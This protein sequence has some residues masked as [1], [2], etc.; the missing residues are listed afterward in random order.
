[1]SEYT[2][3]NSAAVID[4]AISSVAGADATPTDGSQNMVTSGGVKT[5]VDG[6]VGDFAGK[7]VTESTDTFTDSDSS[8]P[9]NAAVVDYVSAQTIVAVCKAADGSLNL[10]ANTP[11]N[12]SI[13]YQ[14]NNSVSISGS[15][16][17]LAEGSYLVQLSGNF[18]E[19]DNDV[20]D[21]AGVVFL[22]NNSQVFETT[23]NENGKPF[24]TGSIGFG[25]TS[26]VSNYAGINHFEVTSGGSST[27][28]VQLRPVSSG[29]TIR[30]K[31]VTLI[32]T[33]LI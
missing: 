22:K 9:T 14:N 12:F 18:N 17:V 13:T 21:I 7:S 32:F 20:N 8:I 26:G 2:L 1:M 24:S 16:V 27:W 10:I 19:Y 25:S 4:A 3:S 5:Y 29:S 30:W 28:S 31:S 11:L 23:F 15:N 33:K 6:A